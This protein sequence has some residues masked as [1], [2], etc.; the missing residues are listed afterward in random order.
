MKVDDILTLIK[1][2]YTKEDIE[3][4]TDDASPV[5]APQPSEESPTDEP[6][7]PEKPKPT[8]AAQPEESSIAKEIAD[9]KKQIL[10]L[11]LVNHAADIPNEADKLESALKKLIG[12]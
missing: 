2:G 3:K 11:S 12:G 4:M 5:P 7:E 10:T 6:A 9:L 1:A 8:E